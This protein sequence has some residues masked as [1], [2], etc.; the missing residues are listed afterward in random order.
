[1]RLIVGQS[2]RASARSSSCRTTT[3]RSRT[4]STWRCSSMPAGSAASCSSGSSARPP[5]CGLRHALAR[6]AA[7]PLF[8]VVYACFVG[9]VCEGLV[10][11]IDH[12]RH[13]Y[14]LMA[15]VWGMMASDGA[16]TPCRS[17]RD[18]GARCEGSD[19]LLRA[20]DLLQARKLG[21]RVG[22]GRRPG[23]RSAPIPCRRGS[24]APPTVARA[25]RRRPASAALRAAISRC[26]SGISEPAS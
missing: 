20:R 15:M 5:C 2:A 23:C 3:T 14:L 16:Q 25:C 8:L 17:V 1:M 7:Q 21:Q 24:A 10:I 4:T 22:D 13:V 18:L 19:S 26:A 9:N 6:G 12:W 11:D